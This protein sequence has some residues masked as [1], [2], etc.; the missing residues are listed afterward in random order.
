M[1]MKVVKIL[2]ALGLVLTLALVTSVAIVAADDDEDDGEECDQVGKVLVRGSPIHGANGI[3]FDDSDMLHIASVVGLG[4]IVIMD[5]KSGRIVDRLGPEQGVIGPDDLAFGPDGSLYWTSIMAGEVGRL[6]DG[7]VTTQFVATGVNPITFSDDGRLFVALDFLGDGLYELD[8]D[9]VDPPRPI[10]EATPSNP[11][12][13]GFLNGMDWGPDGL[14]YGPLWIPGLVVRIDVDSDP[15][16]PEVVASGFSNPAAVKFDSKGNLY[17]ADQMTG[18]ISRVDV[19]TGNKVVM[20]SGL[21]GLDNIAFDSRDRLFVS[22]AQDGSIHRVLRR[23]RIQTIS[24]GGMIVP[25]GVAVMPDPDGGESVFVADLWTLREFDG[26]TGRPGM[27]ERHD[28]AVPGDI[29]SPF[30]V[31]PDGDNLLVSSYFDNKVQVYDPETR[32]V[33]EEYSDFAVPMNAIRF[34]GDIIVAELGTGSVVRESDRIVLAT[35]L[36]IPAGLAAADDDLWVGDWATGQVWQIVGGEAT[37][38]SPK[39][40][41]SGLSNPEGIAVNS[42]GS[43][44]V[45]EAGAGRLSC[46]ELSTGEV[47][48]V[49]EGLELGADGPDALPPTMVFNGVAVGPSGH[50]YVTGDIANVLYRLK[51]VVDDDDD[52]SRKAGFCS[53]AGRWTW[54]GGDYPYPW[55]LP[56]YG[57]FVVHVQ[58]AHH[59]QP[60]KGFGYSTWIT[61]DVDPVTPGDQPYKMCLLVRAVEVA[62]VSRDDG[63]NEAWVMNEVVACS[64]PAMGLVGTLNPVG[65][66]DGGTP[67]RNGDMI[68]SALYPYDFFDDPTTLEFDPLTPQAIYQLGVDGQLPWLSPVTKGN[69]V[70]KP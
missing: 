48:T 5:P 68:F 41:A 38:G 26:R 70:V 43:L 21:C 33:L 42:D 8:P 15:V 53:G 46:I 2:L 20:A 30:T 51:P 19:E 65:W 66:L 6:K 50:I 12:P 3:M 37:P 45:V 14:L 47:T 52:C 54:D 9:L 7:V 10:I 17:V 64:D 58:E 32:V 60:P 25:G 62:I 55:N 18:E 29:T 57:R 56:W 1:K 39:L 35:G 61:D 44:L 16:V 23:G 22:H 59:G 28:L 4:E 34:Q 36:A 49:I 24:R 27:V 67:G 63:S 11:Y 69:L 40:V 13:L 31:S